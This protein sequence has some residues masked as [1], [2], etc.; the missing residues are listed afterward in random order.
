MIRA[1]LLTLTKVISPPGES[2]VLCLAHTHTY[3][4]D[5][6][7]TIRGWRDGSVGQLW[8]M[9]GPGLEPGQGLR[10]GMTEI[11]VVSI[12]MVMPMLLEMHGLLRKTDRS[13]VVH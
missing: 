5:F 11:A 2:S 10:Q 4:H 7:K 6:K 8:D 9:Q 13:S 3:T 12:C 1:W